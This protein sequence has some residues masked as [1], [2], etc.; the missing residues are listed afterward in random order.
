MEE[1]NKKSKQFKTGKGKKKKK[2]ETRK[3]RA[4]REQKQDTRNKQSIL[5]IISTKY[6]SSKL[7]LDIIRS[8]KLYS[9]A[10]YLKTRPNKNTKG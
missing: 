6:E 2:T 4:C 3:S 5:V 10:N 1:K 8:P 7:N 9:A